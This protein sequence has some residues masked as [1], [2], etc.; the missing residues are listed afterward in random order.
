MDVR[1]LL[2]RIET[3]LGLVQAWDE[4]DPAQVKVRGAHA[5]G[6]KG[7][8]WQFLLVGRF[9]SCVGTALR[10]PRT[11]PGVPCACDDPSMVHLPPELAEKA[12]SLAEKAVKNGGRA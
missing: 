4:V 3:D 8:N 6:G 1:E 7:K 12:F 5:Y 11:G 9:G 2:V 10:L